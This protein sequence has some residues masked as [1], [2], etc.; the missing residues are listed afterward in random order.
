MKTY[1]S[2]YMYIY[3]YIY[4]YYM[5]DMYDPNAT[6]SNMQVD[7]ATEMAYTSKGTGRAQTRDQIIKVEQPRQDPTRNQLSTLQKNL[8]R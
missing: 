7:T 2:K 3:I 8:L 5:T 4:I 1:Q 6:G